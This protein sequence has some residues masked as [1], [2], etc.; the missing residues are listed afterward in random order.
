MKTKLVIFDLDG[1]LVENNYDWAA[2]RQE[3]GLN[4]GS[5]LA[6]LDSLP[7]PD[8]SQ[9]YAIL[10]AHEHRQTELAM[11]RPG[12][13]AFLEWLTSRGIKT[14]LVTNN[15]LENTRRLLE[16]FQLTFDLTLTRESGLYKPGAAPFLRVMEQLK[17]KPDETVAVGDTHYDLQ[18]AR[19]AGLARVFILK[20][21]MTPPNLD[22]ATF[23]SS[24]EEI[25][26]YL[27][28]R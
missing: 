16:R 22:G 27:E 20:G 12:T 15:N 1:T 19:E 9:K 8:R 26:P 23:V 21:P 18:A 14:A 6:Y 3:L 7:E 5:I 10:E 4:S 11:L 24:Y 28:E 25:K 13:E 17:V 2:I